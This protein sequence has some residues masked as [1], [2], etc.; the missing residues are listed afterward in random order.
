MLFQHVSSQRV[1]VGESGAAS[2]ADHWLRQLLVESNPD[3][4]V[5][6][7][8]LLDT[9]GPGVLHVD[10]QPVVEAGECSVAREAPEHCGFDIW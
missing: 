10:V 6:D 3:G 9:V 4:V 5:V 8:R 7:G 2:I 1:R